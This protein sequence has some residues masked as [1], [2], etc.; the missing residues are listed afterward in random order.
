MLLKQF[1]NK[2]VLIRNQYRIRANE[3]EEIKQNANELILV[4]KKEYNL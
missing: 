2:F 4:L 1:V 3:L